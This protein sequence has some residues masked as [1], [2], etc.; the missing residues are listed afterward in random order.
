[1]PYAGEAA[2]LSTAVFWAFTSLFFTEASRRVGAFHVNKLRL[3]FAACIYAVV[4]LI[5]SGSPLPTS[6]GR[7]AV[8]WLC[9]SSLIGLVIGDSMLFEAFTSIGP[10]LTTL[11][12]ASSPIMATA[13]AWIFLDEKLN[14][15]DL[16]GIAVTLG[17]IIWVVAERRSNEP[18]SG[19]SD[20]E[21]RAHFRRG[22]LFALGGSLGQAVGLVTSKQAL[23]HTGAAVNPLEAASTR[24]LFAVA[25]M[26]AIGLVRGQIPATLR[27][28]RHK[29]AMLFTVGGTIVGPFLG[30]W[31]SLV[32]VSLIE[33]GV[34]ATLNSM[35]PVVVIPLVI[36]FKKEKVSARAIVGSLVAVGGVALLFLN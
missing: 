12:Y 24:I 34:A 14:V 4:L 26:M 35:V 10:R 9:L 30:I 8:L 22:I 29:E 15:W 31:M 28:A 25:C 3:I 6:L 11:L 21:H 19:M 23:V 13:V 7:D 33:A 32:A 16:V 36:F 20:H 27:A 18:S 2:A 17:G 1:M 5:T